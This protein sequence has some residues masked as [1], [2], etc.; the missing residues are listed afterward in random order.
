MHGTL[1]ISAN[2]LPSRA[3][4]L[5]EM[6]RRKREALDPKRL[7]IGRV[8]RIRTPGLRREEVAARADIG[9][10]WYTK[11]EQG[12]E[13]RVS[14]RVL[15]AVAHALEFNVF[16]TEH[17]FRLAG[18]PVPAR[19]DNPRVCEPLT[20]A[21]QRILDQLCPY[22]AVIQTKRYNI[23]G[24][25][26]AYRRLVGVDLN[27]LPLEDRNCIYLSLVNPAW[28]ASQADPDEVLASM[29][30]LFRASMAEHRDDPSWELQLERYMSVSDQ[31]RIVWDRYQLKAIENV[32]KR[33][34]LADGTILA[35]QSNNWW[36][37]P[38]NDERM[39]VYMPVDDAG[40]EALKAMMKR[41]RAC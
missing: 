14:P 39:I 9:I 38:S 36:A 41:K 16:E 33:F 12:R 29:A 8:G 19:L 21:S 4:E 26:E 13:I 10:T 17:L 37:S 30:A 2:H 40:A 35:L 27:A 34:R 15:F 7:G 32:V 6:L 25:N 28:R 31:F 1:D 18:L 24:F 22:P 3:Q 11:L 20:P 5:G 23:R